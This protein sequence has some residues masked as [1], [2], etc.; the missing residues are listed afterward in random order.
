M[1]LLARSDLAKDPE[2]LVLRHQ[3]AVL[4]RHVKT[5]RLFWSTARSY[6]RWPYRHRSQLRLIVPRRHCAARSMSRAASGA[7]NWAR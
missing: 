6:P 1:A 3:I 4:Q 7:R 5:R 2:I